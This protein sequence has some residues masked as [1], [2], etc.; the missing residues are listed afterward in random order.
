MELTEERL[1]RNIASLALPSALENFL[2]MLVF[3]VD[4]IMVGRLGTEAIAAVGLGGSLNFIITFVFAAIAVAGSSLVARNVGANDFP[5]ARRFAAQSLLLG[6]ALGAVLGPPIVLL[7]EP[8][9][10]LMGAEPAVVKL[11]A[12]YLRIV[13][14]FVIC[15]LILFVG[16]GI[17]RGSGDTVTPMFITGA[18]NVVHIFFNYGLIFGALGFPKLGVAGAGWGTGITFVTGA[19]AM[20]LV[21]T[22]RQREMRITAADFFT[23]DRPVIRTIVRISLPAAL[24][25][26]LGQIG[27]VFFL[28]IVTMLG[29]VS[30]AAHQIAMRAESLGFMPGHAFAVSSATLVG[31]SLGA[32]KH[33]LAALS[34]KRNSQWSLLV[35]GL[36]SLIFVTLPTPLAKMFSP[37][38]DVLR[39]SVRCIMVGALE[40]LPLAFYM[41]YS[42]GLRGAGDTLSPML[43]TTIGIFLRVPVVYLF[44]VIFGWGLVGVW[45]GCAVDWTARAAVVYALFRRGRWRRLQV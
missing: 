11:G 43:V 26:F 45:L 29:T 21:L 28:K 36:I 12:T 38:P 42:G 44:G 24:D 9:L 19:T 13:G 23:L 22:V 20:L 25:T 41:V 10:K 31:Q 37:E 30:L 33:D 18:M 2:H 4:G 40:Q 8:M 5:R 3:I 39:L 6:I 35:M 27:Y 16:G 32:G 1:N 15:R 7:A 14:A 34:M 17:L